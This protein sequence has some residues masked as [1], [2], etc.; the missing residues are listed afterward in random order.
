METVIHASDTLLKSGR[1]VVLTCPAGA[2]CQDVWHHGNSAP[3]S[4][5]IYTIQFC[6]EVNKAGCHMPSWKQKTEMPDSTVLA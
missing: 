5:L 3:S 6:A 4:C 2:P 1:D